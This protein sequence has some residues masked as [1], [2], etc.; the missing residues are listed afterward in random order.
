MAKSKLGLRNT[1][2][3]VAKKEAAQKPTEQK[4]GGGADKKLERMLNAL[5]EEPIKKMTIRV[6][7]SLHRK[8][9]AKVALDDTSLNEYIIGLITD[10]L[11]NEN[12]I[13][14]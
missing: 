8:A 2:K 10:D 9:K 14:E 3:R 5:H 1:S 11:V 13:G 12:R 4:S 6:P 7:I